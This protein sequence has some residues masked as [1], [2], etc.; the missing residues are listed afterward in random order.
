MIIQ[1]Y[2]QYFF[3]AKG[4]I[5]YNTVDQTSGLGQGVNHDYDWADN[6]IVDSNLDKYGNF[7]QGPVNTLPQGFTLQLPGDISLDHLLV[8]NGKTT[9]WKCG[10]KDFEI[11][12]GRTSN[13]PWKSVLN[14][15]LENH[16]SPPIPWSTPASLK[17]FDVAD[18]TNGKFMKFVCHSHHSA[19]V[20]AETYASR[21]SL[22]YLAIYGSQCHNWC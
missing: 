17:N 14:D 7:W 11:L 2:P 9:P 22:Q 19:H 20:N 16:L 1:I 13:G 6:L 10:T 18:T 5:H 12:I 3:P 8:R 15:S 21:C 4:R